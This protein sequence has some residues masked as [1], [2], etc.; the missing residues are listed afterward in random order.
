MFDEEPSAL[1]QVNRIAA[2]MAQPRR[3]DVDACAAIAQG[4]RHTKTVSGL[5]V[6]P[7]VQ[8]PQQS[9]QLDL[10][11]VMDPHGTL[12]LGS[13]RKRPEL[14]FHPTETQLTFIGAGG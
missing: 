11:E 6:L 1:I 7:E 2:H 3:S 5:L 9:S 4:L 12:E 13:R 14:G 10:S 8:A